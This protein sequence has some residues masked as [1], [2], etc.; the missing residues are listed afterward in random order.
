MPPVKAAERQLSA[1]EPLELRHLP[2]E[3]LVFD[4]ALPAPWIQDALKG[5]S[6]GLTF[7]VDAPGRIVL[8]VMP[9]GEVEQH[10][11][12]RLR[13]RVEARLSTDCVR[14]LETV[15]PPIDAEIELTL[16]PGPAEPRDAAK[17]AGKGKSTRVE[18]GDGKLED[19]SADAFPDPDALADASYR[20][21]RVDLPEFIREGL[22]LGLT[23]HPIC[24]D[25]PGCDQR[26]EALLERANG[27]VR[28]AEADV[29]PR[30]AAL[31]NLRLEDEDPS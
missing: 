21:E 9:L 31:K 10:P 11:P 12:V 30:W 26:T 8:E 13:G 23:T 4:E 18:E 2:Q 5:G 15:T 20:G 25:E 6:R 22:L 27:P 7:G 1:L 17:G 28:A 14:C 19:W 24:E 3:G 29:D 16:L